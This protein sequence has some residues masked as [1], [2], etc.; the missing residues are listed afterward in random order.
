MNGDFSVVT[1]SEGLFSRDF[2]PRPLREYFQEALTAG[3]YP[4]SSMAEQEWGVGAK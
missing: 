4:G 1:V 3:A 2:K